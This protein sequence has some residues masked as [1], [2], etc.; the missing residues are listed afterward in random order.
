MWPLLLFSIATVAM[1][2]E[3]SLFWSRLLKTQNAIVRQVISL[4]RS[5][6]SLAIEKLSRHLNLPIPRIFHEALSLED[7]DSDEFALAID[8]AIQAEIPIL[9]RFNDF[10]D[11]IVGLSPLLGLLGTVT[12]LMQSFSNLTLGG[13]DGSKAVGVTSGI[14]VALITTAF[15]LI[16]AIAAFAVASIF[17]SF[18]TRQ[19]ALIQENVAEIELLYRR[20][21]KAFTFNPTESRS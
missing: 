1:V 2:I 15:G 13:V 18:Y 11:L 20:R 19:L 21:Q 6:P 5:D 7:A 3:R 8:G 17:R 16:V 14:S 9:K 12:G 10:F 4:Y